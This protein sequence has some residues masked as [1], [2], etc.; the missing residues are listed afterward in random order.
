MSEGSELSKGWIMRKTALAEFSNWTVA[1]TGYF[2]V[3]VAYNVSVSMFFCYLY[4]LLSRMFQSVLHRK[5]T[6]ISFTPCKFAH[7]TRNLYTKA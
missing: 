3:V 6:A 1:K 2:Q 5:H 4:I 7:G